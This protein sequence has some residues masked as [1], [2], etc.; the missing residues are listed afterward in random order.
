MKKLLTNLA[1]RFRRFTANSPGHQPELV[2]TASPQPPVLAEEKDS[3]ESHPKIS[4]ASIISRQPSGSNSGQQTLK[5]NDTRG[6]ASVGADFIT[7]QELKRE[8]H[9]L[10]RLIESRK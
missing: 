8:L 9:L 4:A 10:R 1:K 3:F 2:P 6:A 5:R 7:R